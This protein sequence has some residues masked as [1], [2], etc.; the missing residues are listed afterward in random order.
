MAGW[1]K[2]HPWRQRVAIVDRPQ[3]SDRAIGRKVCGIQLTDR[4]L[5]HRADRLDRQLRNS[6]NNRAALIQR[7][8]FSLDRGRGRHSKGEGTG[9]R[10]KASYFAVRE[11]ESIGHQKVW[12]QVP[13]DHR[14]RLGANGAKTVRVLLADCAVRQ[15][16]SSGKGQTRANHAI[17]GLK[18]QAADLGC[19]EMSAHECSRTVVEKRARNHR[20]GHFIGCSRI[21]RAIG[22][23]DRSRRSPVAVHAAAGVSG[24]P[25]NTFVV[26]FDGKVAGPRVGTVDQHD[27][28]PILLI[29]VNRVV[30]HVDVVRGEGVSPVHLV[31]TVRHDLTLQSA[32]VHIGEVRGDDFAAGLLQTERRISRK[33]RVEGQI[34]VVVDVR[35]IAKLAEEID[36]ESKR[37]DAAGA[38]IVAW[39]KVRVKA[40]IGADYL[41][42]QGCRKQNCRNPNRSL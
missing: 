19:I 20:S 12:N 8:R 18:L 28:E 40:R 7:D 16:W 23:A 5:R 3:S 42:I 2:I 35:R 13:L 6:D 33:R 21:G 1:Q 24:F 27:L 26:E 4:S 37:S 29:V 34:T 41:S 14:A 31:V 25:G 17:A 32:R 36:R 11:L 39:N 22:P 38:V 10:G 15:D 9:S 30:T